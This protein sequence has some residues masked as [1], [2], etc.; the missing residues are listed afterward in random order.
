MP[1]VYV[2]IGTNLGGREINIIKAKNEILRL[3][4]TGITKES[5]IEE[6]D[7]VDFLAQPK[8]LNQVI[9]LETAIGPFELLRELK[10]I[11][12]RMGRV[13]AVSKGPRIIDL[14]ILLYDDKIINREELTLPHPGILKRRFVLNHLLEIDPELVDPVSG[15]PYKEETHVTDEKH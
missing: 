15:R 10:N 8:F 11:E 12:N 9:R 1:C 13:K 3:P 2:G 14:D 4:G 6:T 7:P 5:S